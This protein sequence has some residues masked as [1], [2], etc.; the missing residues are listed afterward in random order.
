MLRPTDEEY[1]KRTGLEYEVTPDAGLIAL[2]IKAWPLPEGYEPREVDLLIRLPPGFPDTQPDMYWCDPAVR[3][4]RTGGYPQAAEHFE[5]HLGRSWQRFSRHLPA[6]AWHPG[7]DSLESYIA[8]IR[9]ELAR[10]A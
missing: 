1:L 6:G 4:T 8:L 2:V 5:Q 10:T 7:R 9:G 3:L